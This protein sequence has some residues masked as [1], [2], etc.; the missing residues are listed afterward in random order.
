VT[1]NAQQLLACVRAVCVCVLGGDLWYTRCSA[2]KCRMPFTVRQNVIVVLA[3]TFST[4]FEV[5]PYWCMCCI[6]C[7][8][9]SCK[10]QIHQQV[11]AAS[12][13]CRQLR[14]AFAGL[15]NIPLQLAICCHMS[16][17]RR[18]NGQSSWCSMLAHTP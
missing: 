7:M 15:R 13:C 4:V 6:Q 14:I 16:F 3:G 9:H 2:C 1:Y 12:D 5:S 18:A 17:C 11:S 8:M 10:P